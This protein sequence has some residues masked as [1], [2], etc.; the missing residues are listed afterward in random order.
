MSA[1]PPGPST[2]GASALSLER[3]RLLF[4]SFQ[5]ISKEAM[6][7]KPKL[8]PQKV[9]VKSRSSEG[10][11]FTKVVFSLLPQYVLKALAKV[12]HQPKVSTQT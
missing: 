10:L 5:M 6:S 12:A 3:R 1:Y 9:A 2:S 8:E 4:V 7:L 11:P